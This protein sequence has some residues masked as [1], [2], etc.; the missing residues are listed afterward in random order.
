MNFN[1]IKTIY[2]KELREV[3]RDQRTLFLIILLPFFLYPALF[4][5]IGSLGKSQD[6]KLSTETVKVLVNPGGEQTPIYSLLQQDATLDFEVK[7]FD[8]AM[9]DTMKNTIG[10]QIPA[11]YTTL[12]DSQQSAPIQVFANSTKDLLADR[13]NRILGQ[14]EQLN[15]QLLQDRLAGANLEPAFAQPI[16]IEQVDLSTKTARLGKLIGNYL[17]LMLLLFIF[18]GSIYI[19]IDI[20]AG[21]KERRTLQT[22]FTAPVQVKEIIAGKFLAVF[23]VAVTSALMNL[24]SLVVAFWIQVSVMGKSLSG[25]SLS[26]SASG[27]VWLILLI[28]FTAVFL[29]ALSM[30][31]VLLAN[32]YKEAQTYVSP[33]MMVVLIPAI[34]VQ[35]PGLELTLSTALIPMLNI[36]LAMA[37]IFQGSFSVGL[38]AL[39]TGFA[40]LYALLALYFASFT[41][42]NENVITG[43]KVSFKTLFAKKPKPQL[44]EA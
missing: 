5:L 32:S 38:V 33:L 10:I 40:L 9:L 20:T 11:D 4:F 22:L 3:L 21:E 23:T 44:R 12:I 36:C 43:Q 25:I 6:D 35:M 1:I 13:R 29:S 16:A 27:W 28:I 19:A 8:K 7:A 2:F 41:F 15:A 26:I 24:L 17:P 37:A 31:V 18:T 42:G 34:V 14:L 30:S 39:V